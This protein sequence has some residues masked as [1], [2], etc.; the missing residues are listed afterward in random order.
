MLIERWV[1]VSNQNNGYCEYCA[2][3]AGKVKQKTSGRLKAMCHKPAVSIYIWKLKHYQ[4][5]VHY[6]IVE[7]VLPYFDSQFYMIF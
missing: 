6:D 2:Y 5:T 1:D 3:D 7:K 4:I